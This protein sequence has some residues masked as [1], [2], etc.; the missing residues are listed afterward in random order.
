VGKKQITL[1]KA[2][3]KGRVLKLW[4]KKSLGTEILN[5]EEH[6]SCPSE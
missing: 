2:L 6:R 4:L 3:V 1:V 5:R